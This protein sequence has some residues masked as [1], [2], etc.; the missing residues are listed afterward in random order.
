MLPRGLSQA[1]HHSEVSSSGI[2]APADG[3]MLTSSTF[4]RTAR[5]AI[6]NQ[7]HDHTSILARRP[8]GRGLFF[9]KYITA[10][11]NKVAFFLVLFLVFDFLKDAIHAFLSC[12]L[13]LLNGQTP[14]KSKEPCSP[15]L[16]VGN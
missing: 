9:T 16:P 8:E 5:A 13:F 4:T 6:K 1:L 11:Q 12:F 15:T 3:Q 2:H 14:R 10:D 7:N